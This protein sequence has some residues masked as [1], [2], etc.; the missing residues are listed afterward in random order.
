MLILYRII[1]LSLILRS[2]YCWHNFNETQSHVYNVTNSNS[3]INIDRFKL[4]PN[5]IRP[6]D[7]TNGKTLY[8]FFEAIDRIWNHQHPMKCHKSKFVVYQHHWD[9]GFGSMVHVESSLLG[10]SMELG[11]VFVNLPGDALL[12][13]SKPH[14]SSFCKRQGINNMLCYYEPL[15]SCSVSEWDMKSAKKLKNQDICL[16]NCPLKYRKEFNS[17]K[18][19]LIDFSN[20]EFYSK[21]IPTAFSHILE[22][23]RIPV[24]FQYYWWRAVSAAYYIRPNRATLDYLSKLRTLPIT[25]D[26]IC[27]GMHVRHG[28]KDSEMTLIPFKEYA[29]VAETMRTTGL[30]ANAATSGRKIAIFLVTEDPTVLREADAWANASSTWRVV[31]TNL[32]NRENVVAKLN[33]VDRIPNAVSLRSG[34]NLLRPHD[35][36][37]ISMLLNLEYALKCDAWVCTLASNSCRLIDELRATVGG[38]ANKPFADLSQESCSKPPCIGAGIYNFGWRM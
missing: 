17:A 19:L 38:K 34:G 5:L 27:V 24:A 18:I 4:W 2:N 16:K 15:S 26:D 10:I 7:F 1:T 35:L 9:S 14:R 28:D 8:G 21:F 32:F 33:T 36:E 3:I 12:V 30:I 6:Q 25:N 23:S 31:Y 20:I 37:Y 22:S 13:N 29:A 11:R